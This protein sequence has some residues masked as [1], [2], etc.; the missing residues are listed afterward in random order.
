MASAA[1]RI[2]SS[3][4]TKGVL[5]EL[6]PAFERATGVKVAAESIGGVDVNK[7]VKA[8]E[9]VDL[10]VLAAN[11][12]D[13]LI[14]EGH[15]VVGSRVDLVTSGVAIAVRAGAPRPEIGSEAAVKAAV[16]AAKTVCY[17]T[18]P[19]GVTLAKLFE[20][21]GILEEIKARI[22]VA[23]P[24]VP[25][26]GLVARGEAELGFQ[27]MSELIHLPGIDVIGVMPPAIQTITTFSAGIAV[28]SKTDAA[29]L[30]TFLDY[31]R[32]PAAADAI[33]GNGMEAA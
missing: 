21:W 8:G 13:T 11:A 32:S 33:R 3:M 29:A 16:L 18:G 19:S 28:A 17:S 15:L 5:E 23:P 31:A 26:G 12:I 24:G 7:R 27:Q 4:A 30:R 1:I 9:A 2:L 25:V 14:N 10:V 6:A 20:H 22:V